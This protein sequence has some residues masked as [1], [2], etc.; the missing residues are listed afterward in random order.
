[1]N[2]VIPI[3]LTIL[4]AEPCAVLR[5]VEAGWWKV[6]YVRQFERE[7]RGLAPLGDRGMDELGPVTVIEEPEG[8]PCG[9]GGTCFGSSGRTFFGAFTI[10]FSRKHLAQY[11]VLTH[12]LGHA[13]CDRLTPQED[14]GHIGHGT[15][16]D[17]YV[18]ALNAW[19]GWMWPFQQGHSYHPG[20]LPAD[21]PAARPLSGGRAANEW[22][23]A[24]L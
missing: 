21:K 12:E 4:A 23:R 17:P 20:F 13:L 24:E 8:F 22:C 3:L 2:C 14:C 11:D 9:V 7:A 6:K 16:G 1:M 19:I 15:P 10:R 18:L 5:E